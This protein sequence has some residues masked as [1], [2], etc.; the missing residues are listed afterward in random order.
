[1]CDLKLEKNDIIV[2]NA[3]QSFGMAIGS[4]LF[5]SLADICGR[6]GIITFTMVLI[7]SAS[8]ALSFAQTSFL[9]NL[10]ILFL[11]LGLAGNYTVLRVY[12]IECLPMKKREI[13]LAV[14][15]IAWI[16]GYLSALG[17]SWSL[18]PSI[19]RM[20][21]KKFRPNSWRVLA[22]IGGAPSL[23][24]GCAVSLLPETPRFLL[25]QQRQEEAIQV[26]RQIY[27]INNS[28]HIET[29][30]SID[31]N[32]CIEPDEG[33][34]DTNSFFK[35]IYRYCVQMKERI[36]KLFQLPFRRITIY[37]LFL[38]F[39]QF[40]G[41]IWLALWDAHLL[42][43]F[44]KTIIE[45]KRGNDYTCNNN[46]LEIAES[47]LLNCQQIN[48]QRF[49]FLSCI[50][51]SY[52]LGEVLFII[53]IQIVKKKWI[54]IFSSIIGGLAVLS[55]IFVVQYA[56]QIILSV[57]FLA[58]YAINHTIVNVLIAENYPTGLR[59]TV[60]GFTRIL[61]HL[62]GAMIKFISNLSCLSSIIVASIIFISGAF[63]VIPMPDLTRAPIQER[64]VH[65][66]DDT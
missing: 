61:P 37:S 24:I 53:G 44:G 25:Y 57:I 66:D 34:Q 16:L 33:I 14:V 42:Q 48:Q 13:C 6:K 64:S 54:L 32:T 21:Y 23:I 46:F 51:F 31:L 22:G 26:L 27:A 3:T 52:L 28:K 11:G 15:D 38:C 10:F 63:V 8:I 1:M 45:K 47:L 41:F 50:S 19:I 30:P 55:V 4:F 12:L 60:M 49:I 62:T 29:Y 7:F 56:M 20:L 35:M 5:G 43:E 40:P 36:Q 9:M 39:L 58:S 17:L 59:G 2:F 65:L 18:V